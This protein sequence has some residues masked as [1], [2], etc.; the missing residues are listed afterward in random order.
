MENLGTEEKYSRK[1]RPEI[2][3]SSQHNNSAF[4]NLD[5]NNPIKIN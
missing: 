5:H 4:L 2:F 3:E 1:N